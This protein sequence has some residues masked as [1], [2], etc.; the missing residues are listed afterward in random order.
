MTQAQAINVGLTATAPTQV[1]NLQLQPTHVVQAVQPIHNV[2]AA[3][4]TTSATEAP[5]DSAATQQLLTANQWFTHHLLL[6]SDATKFVALTL[7]V[8]IATTSVTP[9]VTALIAVA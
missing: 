2:R 7:T 6:Q 9:L 1:A 8:Q 4:P 5:A 3:T